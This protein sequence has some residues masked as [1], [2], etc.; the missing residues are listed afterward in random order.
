MSGL[1]DKPER[2][3]PVI[4]FLTALVTYG[5]SAAPGLAILDSGEFLGVAQTL[6]VA[7][8]TGYPFYTLLGHLA[9][10]F[11]YRDPAWRINVLASALPGAA[12]AFFL[13]L[14]AVEATRQ[15]GLQGRA[16][17]AAALA[18]GALT[19]PSRTLWSIATVA[20]VY[21]LNAAFWGALL[22]L[23]LLAR[24]EPTLNRAAAWAFVAGLSFTNHATIILF[25]VA[26]AAVAFVR[27]VKIQ[28]AALRLPAVT[29]FFLAGASVNLYIPLR[30]A[31]KTLFN[32]NDPSDISHF[33]KHLTGAQYR[34]NF[35]EGGWPG[36]KAALALLRDGLFWNV[37]PA[38]VVAALGLV[39]L[40]ARRFRLLTIALCSYAVLYIFYCCA[41]DIPDIAFYFI[42]IYLSVIFF[43]ACGFAGL[44]ATALHPIRST[45]LKRIIGGIVTLAVAAG[46]TASAT[47]NVLYGYRGRAIFAEKW[48]TAMLAS[49]PYRCIF[50]PGGDT[51]TFISWYN[52]FGR[53]R[54]PDVAVMD[55][56][57]IPSHGYLA[58][59]K[60]IYPDLK[61]PAETIVDE[62][63]MRAIARGEYDGRLVDFGGPNDFI[64]PEIL[65][66]I[67]T[68]NI[69]RRRV[70]WGLSNPGDK[71]RPYIVPYD[72]TTEF[73]MDPPAG[74]E[75]TLRGDRAAAALNAV[76]D[77]VRRESP[78]E[79]RDP[80]LRQ[81]AA[82]YYAALGTHLTNWGLLASALP[83]FQSY[84]RNFPDD[85]NGYENLGTT[86]MLR[87]EPAAAVPYYYR[88]IAL[89]PANDMLRLRL[90][91]ALLESKQIGAAAKFVADLKTP[92]PG[93]AD[94][95]RG[96]V[97]RETKAYRKALRSFA[98]A[99]PHYA[100][101]ATFWLERGKTYEA[102]G[103]HE[104]ALGAF[105][106]AITIEPDNA[107][108][109]TARGVIQLRLGN[110]RA[111]AAD[112]HAAL[113][114]QPGTAQAHY[115]LACIYA[116]DG[117]TDR[118]FHHLERAL[119][120]NP[121]RYVALARADADLAACRTS[122]T[123]NSL[124]SK[125]ER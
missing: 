15:I 104:N 86:F 56:I 94:Y 125:Y 88:A 109:L 95:L 97:Y 78:S 49:L 123:F 115:N 112:F 54:R 96:I 80:F 55:Q 32:W 91:I 65:A 46:V 9:T 22:W 23:A 58:G 24:R 79:L 71:L 85:P 25:I 124:L 70:I 6:G 30:A 11:P 47:T 8:P 121:S 53:G 69:E 28:V 75:L 76:F 40:V 39:F 16:L 66:Q 34:W 74:R 5:V 57:R 60:R 44:I 26:T 102:A 37:T 87:G 113:N 63:G 27:N 45:I 82:L 59:L 31:R 84:V 20:E 29:V 41:Y 35:F 1:D 99:A 118:A 21:A 67:I 64:L 14:A 61:L 18:A 93:E 98:A 73:L 81:L 10:L 17:T 105:T 36:A 106:R 77:N 42:P 90:V 2:W 4:I 111:A 107:A 89:S 117:R 43:T 12:A 110:H 38:G 33:F 83:L 116:L 119:S 103:D 19:I 51:N 120:L 52:I 100:D 72:V 108:A 48:G 92:E 101:D 7:H 13:A 122:P 62:I 3:A 114:L 68:D 50:M